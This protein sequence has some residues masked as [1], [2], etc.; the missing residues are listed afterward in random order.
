MSCAE[1]VFGADIADTY[2]AEE[3]G[4]IAAQCRDCGEYHISAEATYVEVARFQQVCQLP[5][6]R[7]DEWW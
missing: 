2:G 4:H 6:V 7:S 1:V 5:Q 3:V